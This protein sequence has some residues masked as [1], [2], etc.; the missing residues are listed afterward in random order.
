MSDMTSILD[1]LQPIDTSWYLK[2]V[3]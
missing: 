3:P 1:A 2:C